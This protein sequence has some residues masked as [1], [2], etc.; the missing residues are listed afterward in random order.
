[1]SHR[2]LEGNVFD[3]LPGIAPGSIDAVCTSPPYWK[4]RAYLPQGHPLKA[5]EIGQEATPALFVEKIVRVMRLVRDCLADHGVCWLNIGDSYVTSACGPRGN[6]GTLDGRPNFLTTAQGQGKKQVHGQPDGSLCLVPQRLAIALADDGW[7]VRSVVVWHKPSA[8]PASLAGWAWRRHRVK[9]R[10][11]SLVEMPAKWVNPKR[12]EGEP[13]RHREPEWQDCPGC[14]KCEKNLIAC[15][16]CSGS[17]IQLVAATVLGTVDSVSKLPCPDCGGRGANG[18]V[19]R[20]GSWRPTSAWEPVLMLAKGPGYFSDGE[21]VKTPAAASTVSRDRYTRVLDDPDEQFAV[22]HDHETTCD[23]G[24]NLR[25]VWTI[26][27][28]PLKAAHYAAFPTELVRRCLLSSVS[29][30]GYCRGCGKPWVRVISVRGVNAKRVGKTAEKVAAGLRTALSGAEY[31]TAETTTLGWRPSC[32]CHRRRTTSGASP[33]PVRRKLTHG[34]VRGP[35]GSGLHRDR[36]SPRL[37][38]FE[39][40]AAVGRHAALPGRPP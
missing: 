23:S 11:K 20:K 15:N 12:H 17:G 39:P 16:R 7:I 13:A 1:V 27:A 29:A 6:P 35:H 21:P 5:L 36:A 30:K 9:V 24:A 25:D 28:E 31:D 8:M 33:G 2:I 14:P 38:L 3:V 19:L 26:G 4:L 18:Y 22:A 10:D 37:R 32:K 40:P 34:S